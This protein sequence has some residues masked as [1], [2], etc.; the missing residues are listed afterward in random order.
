MRPSHSASKNSQEFIQ[1]RNV[2]DFKLAKIDKAV[3]CGL[4][5]RY[6]LESVRYVSEGKNVRS[7]LAARVVVATVHPS[8]PST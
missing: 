6:A 5:W 4:F 1:S 8:S 3:G 7:E 2:K